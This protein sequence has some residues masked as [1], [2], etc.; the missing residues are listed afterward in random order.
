MYVVCV[1]VQYHTLYTIQCEPRAQS[2][3]ELVT[4]VPSRD[5]ETNT[6]TIAR[7]IYEITSPE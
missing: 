1:C 6:P 7:R 4:Y 2:T 3:V 5:L